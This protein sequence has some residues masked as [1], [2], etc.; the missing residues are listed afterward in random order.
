MKRL[1][2]A[3]AACLIVAL[4][5][6]S[7]R[8]GLAGTAFAD[9]PPSAQPVTQPV[10]QP[11]TQ[12]FADVPPSNPFYTYIENLY[13]DNVIGGYQGDGVTINPCTGHVE[14]AGS[15]YFR[16]CLN[17]TR[18]QN[19]K[20]EDNGRRRVT[21]AWTG[22]SPNWG[23]FSAINNDYSA[24]TNAG[25]Y[26]EGVRG[27]WGE[28]NV[29]GTVIS[30]AG[31]FYNSSNTTVGEFGVEGIT[32]SPSAAAV[33]GYFEG[34]TGA[35]IEDQSTN[36]AATGDGLDVGGAGSPY[37]AIYSTEPS[38]SGN[39]TLYG[40]GHIHGSN[41]AAGEY[42]QEAVYDGAA[43][44][45]L[46]RVVALD[47]A[48]V[49]G[50]PLGVVP[51]DTDNADAA[52]GVVSYRLD[53]VKVNGIDKT[54]IDAIAGAVQQGDRVYITFAGRTKMHLDT[55]TPAKVGTRLTVGPDGTAV[56]ASTDGLDV[57]FGKVASRPSADGTVDVIVS[58]K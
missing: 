27:V 42:E 38:G 41:I 18:G 14:Q 1:T 22:A 8:A 15:L 12:T 45:P 30:A 48:N 44:L 13:A 11:T 24:S 54:Y 6:S 29:T 56:A 20:F 16:P 33:G 10:T 21:G 50:G 37:A 3:L 39:Y 34:G 17:V 43:P 49:E 25:V 9:P 35:V 7:G 19:S 31:F 58:F 51:A 47:P 28:S 52:I 26:G 40:A 57:T 55:P 53:T 46:G 32:A 5:T 36:V 2:L 4:V 23:I